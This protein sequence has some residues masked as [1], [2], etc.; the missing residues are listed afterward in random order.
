MK[1]AILTLLVVIVLCNVCVTV[2][3]HARHIS[4]APWTVLC[5]GEGHY[6]YTWDDG[7]LALGT[8]YAT[9]EEAER[10]MLESKEFSEDYDAHQKRTYK[11]CPPEPKP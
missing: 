10:R 3:R 1:N 2:A 5:D 9:R 7:S 11:P 4:R 8:G 6:T